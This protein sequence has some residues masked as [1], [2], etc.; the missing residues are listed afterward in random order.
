MHNDSPTNLCPPSSI[1]AYHAGDF[2][3]YA[4]FRLG[5]STKTLNNREVASILTTVMGLPIMPITADMTLSEA[6]AYL[7]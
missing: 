2:F 7:F 3:L 5:T 6:K 1:S 4:V